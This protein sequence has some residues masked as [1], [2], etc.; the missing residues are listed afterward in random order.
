M[1][2]GIIKFI[3]L[4]ILVALVGCKDDTAEKAE[5]ARLQPLIEAIDSDPWIREA[6]FYKKEDVSSILIFVHP[7]RDIAGV[8]SAACRKTL[9]FYSS[10][11]TIFLDVFDDSEKDIIVPS[12]CELLG[13]H[14]RDGLPAD[15]HW[16]VIREKDEV[17]NKEFTRIRL[18]SEEGKS[19]N[20]PYYWMEVYCTKAG[21]NLRMDFDEYLGSGKTQVAYRLDDQSEATIEEWSNSRSG[22][23]LYAPNSTGFISDMFGKDIL[24]F[25]VYANDKRIT[26][27]FK[28]L[29]TKEAIFEFSTDCRL[30]SLM[31][32]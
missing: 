19:S 2:R 32:Q 3:S 8:A 23:S 9:D 11:P 17:L 20:G 29:G 16:A 30:L 13:F 12:A 4:G 31:K 14:R 5:I 18:Q 7:N 1:H 24:R 27:S 10:V 15:S 22:K 28:L 26:T 25:R 21:L 6:A